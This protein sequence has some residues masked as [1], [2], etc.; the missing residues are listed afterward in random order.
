MNGQHGRLDRVQGFDRLGHCV[1]NVMQLEIEKDR[2]P[3]RGQLRNARGT[4][5]REELQPQLQSTDM[6]ADRPGQQA[7]TREVRCIERNE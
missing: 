4:I 5:S 3:E 1:G 2:L 7:R 6:I